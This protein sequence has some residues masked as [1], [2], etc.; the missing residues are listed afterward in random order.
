MPAPVI[1]D[2]SGSGHNLSLGAFDSSSIAKPGTASVLL[3]Q[4]IK[5]P[6]KKT[7]NEMLTDY[8]YDVEKA[9]SSMMTNLWKTY[10]K[11]GLKKAGA[12]LWVLGAQYGKEAVA[13][14]AGVHPTTASW[15][16]LRGG[17]QSPVD[18]AKTGPVGFYRAR[19][20]AETEATGS[21]DAD[22]RRRTD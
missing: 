13:A 8:Q 17:G 18:Q 14:L 6:F 15:W 9:E 4:N 20:V 16:I 3:A 22:A 10:M 1:Y 5:Q 12:A 19:E 7:F 11:P 21:E 2:N